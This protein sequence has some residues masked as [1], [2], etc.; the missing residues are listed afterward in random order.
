MPRSDFP[1]TDPHRRAFLHQAAG[2]L[3]AGLATLCTTDTTST[4]SQRNPA[5]LPTIHLGPHAVTRLI[6]GGNP[7]YGHSHFNKLLSQHQVAWHTPER[8]VE[9]LQRCEQAGINTWQ[10]SY[11]KRTLGDLDRFRSAGGKLHWLCLGKTDWDKYPERTRGRGSNRRL[12]DNQFVATTPPRLLV[13]GETGRRDKHGY[14]PAP[15]ES[16]SGEVSC[17]VNRYAHA[18]TLICQ[19][20]GNTRKRP[21]TEDLKSLL[22]PLLCGPE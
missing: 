18:P 15:S 2:G 20:P 22:V 16:S 17:E 8:V 5:I 11:D 21:H 13:A 12:S 6:V 10:S 7:I 9:L 19:V 1:M 3:T 14:E 4:R